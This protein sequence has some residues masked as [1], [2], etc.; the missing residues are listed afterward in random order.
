MF[1]VLF[2][3]ISCMYKI[4]NCE[5]S[6]RTITVHLPTPGCTPVGLTRGFATCPTEGMA[7]SHVES[8]SWFRTKSHRV[9]LG[10]PCTFLGV[11]VAFSL[12]REGNSRHLG[13]ILFTSY[14]SLRSGGRNVKTVQTFRLGLLSIQRQGS[15]HCMLFNCKVIS[16]LGYK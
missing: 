13:A 1:T 7:A 12:P 4:L 9:Q 3:V 14:L 5:D 16:C 8:S 10:P 11:K 6:N 15:R 2:S